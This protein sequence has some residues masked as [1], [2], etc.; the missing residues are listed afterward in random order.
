MKGDW[1]FGNLREL[2]SEQINETLTEGIQAFGS[3]IPGFDREDMVLSGVESRTSSPVRI[4]RDENFQCN[5]AGIYPC[6]RGRRLC[7][8][9]YFCGYGWSE[10]GGGN[11]EKNQKFILRHIHHFQTVL[12]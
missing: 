6:A 5:I 4:T 12:Q 11:C 2:F 9:H 1:N 3:I 7:G 10:S 8:R